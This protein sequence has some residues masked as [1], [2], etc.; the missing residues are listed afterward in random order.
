MI[1]LNL[2]NLFCVNFFDNKIIIIGGY[3]GKDNKYINKFIQ[4]IL[5]KDNFENNI[6]VE[7][8]ERKFKDIEINKKY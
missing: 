5:D 8:T 7:E 2:S 6:I 3:N 4:F 1:S